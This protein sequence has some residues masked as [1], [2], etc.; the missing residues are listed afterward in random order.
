MCM[1]FR[2]CVTCKCCVKLLYIIHNLPSTRRLTLHKC[3]VMLFSVLRFNMVVK[4]LNDWSEI[5]D[6]RSDSYC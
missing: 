2:L 6:V 1:S 3:T 4:L 5:T